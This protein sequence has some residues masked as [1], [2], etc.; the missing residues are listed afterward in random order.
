MNFDVRQERSDITRLIAIKL[1]GAN[2]DMHRQYEWQDECDLR[3]EVVAII[4]RIE[5]PY[6]HG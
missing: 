6:A 1:R 4:G 5:Q 2:D 3:R